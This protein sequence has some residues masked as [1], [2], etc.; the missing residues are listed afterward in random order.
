MGLLSRQKRFS[1]WIKRSFITLH[2]FRAVT[3]SDFR[4]TI[5][6]AEIILD[7]NIITVS[8]E[9]IAGLVTL[10]N[11]SLVYL[12]FFIFTNMLTCQADFGAGL[13]TILS[14]VQYNVNMFHDMIIVAN[15]DHYHDI[16]WNAIKIIFHVL[17]YTTILCVSRILTIILLYISNR[18]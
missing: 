13:F 9:I 7:S 3:I 12:A 17:F 10:S 11:S 5:I 18:R 1:N 15:L 16:C 2:F 14:Y 6:V 8:G 4:Q